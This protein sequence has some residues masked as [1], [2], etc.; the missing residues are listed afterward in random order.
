MRKVIETLLITG[1]AYA[2]TLVYTY[3]ALTIS[4]PETIAD[5]NRY[6]SILT[7][8]AGL[9]SLGLIQNATREIALNPDSWERSYKNTQ[10]LRVGLSIAICL[11]SIILY[12][13]TQNNI[14]LL[15][16]ASLPM[17]LSGEYALYALGQPTKGSLASL[18][19]AVV[20]CILLMTALIYTDPELSTLTICA[21]SGLSY[22]ICGATASKMLRTSYLPRLRTPELAE[23]KVVTMLAL[24]VFIYNNLK[25]SLIL[26]IANDISA[27]DHSYYFEAYKLFFILFSVRRVLVQAQYSEIMRSLNSKRHDYLITMAM[28]AC[29]GCLWLIKWLLA[30]LDINFVGLQKDI[31]IDVS[32]ITAMSCIAPTAFTKI[33]A[34]KKDALIILPILTTALLIFIGAKLIGSGNGAISQYLYLLGASELALSI[35]CAGIIRHNLKSELKA[36]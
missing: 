29:I 11:A 15:G 30:L 27:E 12:C 36:K 32:I 9:V 31:L 3:T 20:F 13:T 4:T 17:A 25:P 33:F 23:L 16:L 18:F 19:R 8:I 10:S 14:Y 21:I 1:A 2:A 34:L 7:I 26:V 24:V 28:A 35:C 5:L 6:E 22:L